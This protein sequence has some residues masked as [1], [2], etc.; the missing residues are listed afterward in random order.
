[1]VVDLFCK[2]S[3]ADRAQDSC[4]L[5]RRRRHGSTD[6]QMMLH[7]TE[8]LLLKLRQTMGNHACFAGLPIQR[9][10]TLSAC[11]SSLYQRASTKCICHATLEESKTFALA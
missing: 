7:L 3:E 8:L 6:S 5:D 10:Y 2:D 4:Q 11:V 1:M 9:P